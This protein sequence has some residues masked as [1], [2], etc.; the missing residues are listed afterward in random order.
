M[1][2]TVRTNLFRNATNVET[3]KAGDVIFRAG[4]DARVMYVVQSGEVEMQIG[5]LREAVGEGEIFGEMALIDNA[6]RSATVVA[7][8]DCTIVPIDEKR[9]TFLVDETPNFALTVMRA[10]SERLRRRQ[11][12]TQP[13]SAPEETG[14]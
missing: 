6:P 1:A 13:P 14:A 11:V 8:T 12:E 7:K 9:F 10:M 4:D 3:Y 2:T 5:D